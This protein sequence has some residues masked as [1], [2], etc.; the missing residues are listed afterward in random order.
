MIDVE[1]E[2]DGDAAPRRVGE[3]ACDETGRGLLEVEVVEGE[4]EGAA[5]GGDELARV[6]G[7]LEGA[8]TAVRECPNLDR[9][10]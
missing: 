6:L 2:A 10:A 3:R 5:G 1:R 7:D 9:Q 4:I 8:L